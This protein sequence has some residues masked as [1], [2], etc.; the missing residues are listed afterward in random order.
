MEALEKGPPIGETQALSVLNIYKLLAA[1]ITCATGQRRNLG[2]I[3][4]IGEQGS[5]P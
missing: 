2:S 1:A 4:K 3:V 5:A